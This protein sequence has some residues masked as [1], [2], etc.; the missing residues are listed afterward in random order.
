MNRKTAALSF[1]GVCL[2]LAMLLVAKAISPILSGSIFAIALVA[3]G[4][5]SHGFTYKK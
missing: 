2:V 1:L 4:I 5:F 3:F